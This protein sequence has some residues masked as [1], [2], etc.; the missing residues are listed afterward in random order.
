MFARWG[1]AGDMS[2]KML[3]SLR[4]INCSA[5]K[6]DTEIVKP[7]LNNLPWELQ[8]I[9]HT[10]PTKEGGVSLLISSRLTFATSGK[11]WTNEQGM[12]SSRQTASLQTFNFYSSADFSLPFP[13]KQPE[14]KISLDLQKLLGFKLQK[15]QPIGPVVTDSG[16]YSPSLEE[17]VF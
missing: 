17:S 14:V 5:L 7:G 11:E 12:N 8:N 9:G 3:P 15:T 6:G 16:S 1:W 4:E 13:Q 10:T 2:Q